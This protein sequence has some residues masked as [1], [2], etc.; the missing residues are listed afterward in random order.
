MALTRS[1]NPIAG[2]FR[3]AIRWAT[4]IIL[5]LK[6]LPHNFAHRI[7]VVY[8]K[9]TI[10]ILT[11]LIT[12]ILFSR[13]KFFALS[14]ILV[15][16]GYFGTFL[17]GIL[18]AYSFTA[19]PSTAVFL[20]LAKTENIYLAGVIGGIGALL[21]DLLIFKLVRMS[22]AD[23]IKKLHDEKFFAGISHRTPKAIKTYLVPVVAALIIASP[24]P[25]EIGVSMLAAY[26]LISTRLFSVIS[27]VLNTLGIFMVLKIGTLI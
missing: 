8:P 25:D 21:G 23:E 12:Y 1:K 27:F 4:G 26:P 20:I 5:M 15:S 14:N 24:L 2:I 22:F 10:L 9:F 6:G 3:L 7:F 13:Y 19:A 18:F 16:L 17:T 11:F